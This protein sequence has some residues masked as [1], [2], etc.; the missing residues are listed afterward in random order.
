MSRTLLRFFVR[1]FPDGPQG[2]CRFSGAQNSRPQN[3]A[4]NQLVEISSDIVASGT[5]GPVTEKPEEAQALSFVLLVDWLR[6]SH[7]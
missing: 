2:L 6:G 3:Q 1:A 7:L 4:A 5:A